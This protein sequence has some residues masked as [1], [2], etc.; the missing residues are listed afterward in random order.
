MSTVTLE[1]LAAIINA[2]MDGL[3]HKMELMGDRISRLE[4]DLQSR[5]E[6]FEHT[7]YARDTFPTVI[8]SSPSS[9]KS[10]PRVHSVYGVLRGHTW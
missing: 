4:Y 7:N 8:V 6:R 5:F 3:E 2:R 1:S 10:A 9:Y